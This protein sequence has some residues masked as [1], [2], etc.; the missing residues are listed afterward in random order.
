MCPSPP[1]LLEVAGLSDSYP[2]IP[3]GFGGKEAVAD[4]VEYTKLVFTVFSRGY[5]ITFLG[6]SSSSS[7][8]SA[9][10]NEYMTALGVAR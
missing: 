4:A 7:S 5:L 9:G 8:T 3:F 10:T 6:S 2:V 1:E